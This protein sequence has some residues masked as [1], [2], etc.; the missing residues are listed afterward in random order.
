MCRV[1]RLRRD[2]AEAEKELRRFDT[3]YKKTLIYYARTDCLR[4]ATMMY[5]KLPQELRELVYEY[6][7]VDPDR[8]IP[9]GPYYHFRP[10]DRPYVYPPPSHPDA[11]SDAPT[12]WLAYGDEQIGPETPIESV[13]EPHCT[14][15]VWDQNVQ[16]VPELVECISNVHIGQ[17]IGDDDLGNN[18][19]I[20]P[21]G[22][23]KEEHT[24]QSPS[25]MVLPS[26]HFLDPRYVGPEVSYEMQKMY[27]ARNT[28]SVCTVDK[29]IGNF[30]GRPTDYSILKSVDGPPA[31]HSPGSV[32]LSPLYAAEN[33]RKLQIRVKFEHFHLDKP[34]RE[35]S[36]DDYA[37]EQRFWLKTCNQLKGL[38]YYLDRRPKGAVEIEFVIMS[39]L[40]NITHGVPIVEHQRA[41]AER[42]RLYVNFLQ[43]IRNTVYTTIYDH[44]DVSV[45]VTHYDPAVAAF[46]RDLTRL[47]ALT[48]G[49]WEYVS[50]MRSFEPGC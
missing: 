17:D 34:E 35:C 22:R 49:Q 39:Q 19:K 36:F 11:P 40:P 13:R 28:F 21:D 48:K 31:G 24:H 50:T 43:C 45:K 2:L 26:S 25:D 5:E 44:E 12:G 15:T 7:C 32:S 4:L 1:E 47:F 20:L 16:V 14:S 27:Y 30:L 8:P 18:C 10:Y 41:C 46:P 3:D 29:A 37:Y 6:L 33:I 23:V 38:T 9:V 42:D